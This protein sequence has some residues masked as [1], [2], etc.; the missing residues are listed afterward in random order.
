MSSSVTV[1]AVVFSHNL[2]IF[3]HLNARFHGH[4]DFFS[5]NEEKKMS[6]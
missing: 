4:R 5:N 2:N 3:L 6:L 1:H